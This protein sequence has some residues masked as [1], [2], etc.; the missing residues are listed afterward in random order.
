LTTDEVGARSRPSSWQRHRR[1]SSPSGD[2]ESPWLAVVA[3]APRQCGQP[4]PTRSASASSAREDR[5]DDGARAKG[6]EPQAGCPVSP[7]AMLQ[8]HRPG[9]HKPRTIASQIRNIVIGTG[10]PLGG[11][12]TRG[13]FYTT[14]GEAGPSGTVHQNNDGRDERI[15][16]FPRG[17]SRPGGII[18]AK[19]AGSR[20]RAAAV[21]ITTLPGCSGRDGAI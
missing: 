3:A 11:G 19:F 12:F 15:L 8:Q 10:T 2:R 4:T 18:G 16:R 14:G 1:P 17:L 21:A 5:V 7:E 9:D 6:V 20:A 13:A